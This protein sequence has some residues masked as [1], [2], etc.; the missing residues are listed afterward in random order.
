[1]GDAWQGGSPRF[2][3]LLGDSV[4]FPRQRDA[5]PMASMTLGMRCRN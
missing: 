5:L 2:A 3:P 4:A 1:M